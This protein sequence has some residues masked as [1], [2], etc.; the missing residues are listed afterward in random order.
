MSKRLLKSTFTIGGMTTISRVLGLIRDITISR[1]FGAGIAVDAFIVAFR[2]PNFWRRIFAEG[3]FSQVFVPVLSEYKQKRGEEAVDALIDQTAATLG[4]ALF[5]LTALGV[6]LAPLFIMVFAPGFLGD[7]EK[8]PLAVDMLRITFPYLLFISL[9]AFSA[10]ILNTYQRFAAPAIMPALLNLSLIGCAIWLSPHLEVPIKALAWGVLIAGVLQLILQV[11]FLHRIRK[12]PKPGLNRDRQGM[13]K[14][15]KL[16]LPAI[17]AV[18]I[19]QINLLV[20][21][22][23]A[24][25]LT[26]GSISWL[27]FSNRLVEF[28]LGVFGIALATA[29]LPSLSQQYAD[30]STENFSKTLNWGLRWVFLIGI[31]ATAG[32]AIL[33][34]PLLTTLFYY[35]EFTANDVLM[36]GKSL[37]AYSAGLLGFILIKILAAGFFSHQETSTPVKA[38][39]VAMVANIILNLILVFPL[40]HAGLALA[41]SLSAYIQA[42]ILY[43]ALKRS[44]RIASDPGRWKFILRVVTAGALMSL[45]LLEFVAAPGVWREWDAGNRCIWLLFWVAAGAAVYFSSLWLMGVRPRHMAT[46]L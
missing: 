30:G 18:S 12:L 21:T 23:I 41:T 7:E 2:I 26:T 5:V 11:P 6:L 44:G 43:Y 42:A 38:G 15:F 14:I 28:P 19:V 46:G 40:A 36:S 22:L 32:L 1:L 24:S 10:G 31:P 3:S 8:Y 20:D 4:L 17:F 9:T 29:I 35:N 45:L 37:M 25:L 27:Y 34:D 39:V 16:M 33:A 13:K